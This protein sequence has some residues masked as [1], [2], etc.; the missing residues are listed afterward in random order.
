MAGLRF[1]SRAFNI[2][3]TISRDF[4][5]PITTL[6]SVYVHLFSQLRDKDAGNL[7]QDF[8]G[9]TLGNFLEFVILCIRKKQKQK[10]EG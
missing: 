9:G 2:G 6:G 10:P 1:E 4:P 3:S 5:P 7:P 8:L